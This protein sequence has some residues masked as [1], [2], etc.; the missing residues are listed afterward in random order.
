MRYALAALGLLAL[1]IFAI[2]TQGPSSHFGDTLVTGCLILAAV[3]L[4]A[5]AIVSRLDRVIRLLKDHR[6]D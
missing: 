3:L 5:A 6:R 4:S 1:A 2:G